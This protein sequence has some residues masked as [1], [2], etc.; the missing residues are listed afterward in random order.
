MKEQKNFMRNPWLYVVM[1]LV[2]GLMALLSQTNLAAQAAQNESDQYY[3]MLSALEYSGTSQFRNEIETLYAVK[4]LASADDKVR[5]ILS[6]NDEEK[7]N[8]QNSSTQSSLK[9]MSFV[10]DSKTQKISAAG[11]DLAFLETVSN[12]CTNNLKKVTKTNIGKTWKQSFD[13]STLG[14]SAPKEIKFTLTAIQVKTESLGDVIAVRALSEPFSVNVVNEKGGAGSL[15]CKINSVYVFDKEFKDIYLSL[16]LFRATTNINGF[17]ETLQ[18]TVAARMTDADGKA[19]DL[20]DLGK[21]K[22]FDKFVSKLGITNKLEV[23]N[24]ASLPQWAKS[25]GIK[26][27]QVAN[28]CAGT[29]CEGALNP[30]ASVF[31]PAARVVELQGSSEPITKNIQLAGTGGRSGNMFEWFG[32]NIPTAIFVGGVTYGTLGAAGAF[33]ETET[34]YRSPAD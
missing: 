2:L 34:K 25:E 28:I 31:M 4:R 27:A 1:L 13:L 32:W 26:T 8:K 20:S 12:Q 15:Q 10:L 6:T 14:G 23:V 19:A 21:N 33:N 5:Y 17:N 18:H 11:E 3:K 29:S 24:A 16:S 7:G 30:V 22:D 9:N